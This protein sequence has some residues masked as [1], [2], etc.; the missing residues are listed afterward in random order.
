MLS[1]REYVTEA[2]IVITLY[3]LNASLWCRAWLRQAWRE[4]VA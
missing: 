3:A 4:A 1:R 2:A